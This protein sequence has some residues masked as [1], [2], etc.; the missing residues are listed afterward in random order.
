MLPP[1]YLELHGGKTQRVKPALAPAPQPPTP[2]SP[3]KALTVEAASVQEE[4]GLVEEAGDGKGKGKGKGK[5]TLSSDRASRWLL[6]GDEAS[7]DIAF[8]RVSSCGKVAR[9]AVQ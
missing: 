5:T 1:G 7:G 8:M 3:K 4:A 2:K 9:V 6:S